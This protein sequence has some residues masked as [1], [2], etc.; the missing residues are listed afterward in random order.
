MSSRPP[1]S[2]KEIARQAGLSLATIDRV[3][4]GRASAS[5]ATSKRVK[6]AVKELKNQG[7][8][9]IIRG[10][11][12]TID[13]V[14]EAPPRF[15]ELVRLALEYEILQLQPAAFRCRFHGAEILEVKNI[16]ELLKSIARRGSNGLILK[17]PNIPIIKNAIDE[18]VDLGIPV[19]TLVTDI[20][21]SKRIAY[22]GIDNRAAGETAAYLMGSWLAQKP[23]SILITISSK[24]FNGEVERQLAFTKTLKRHFPHLK[25]IVI[26][27]GFGRNAATQILAQEAMAQEPE[28]KAAYSVGGANHSVLEAFRKTNRQ[29]DVFIAHDLDADNRALLGEGRINAVLHHDLH[30]DMRRCCLHLLQ[31]N[32][33][34]AHKIEATKSAIQVITPYN[35]P[36]V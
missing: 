18:L 22:V 24:D 3:L 13:I 12:F 10:R 26:S 31:A 33:V 6:Q 27:E 11:K 4:H 25:T 36:D 34:L 5:I 23:A 17:V 8:L 7:E 9:S 19:I 14:M 15:S 2:M 35:I 16:I 30:A 20:P 1:F 21:K 29:C 28:I 32:G